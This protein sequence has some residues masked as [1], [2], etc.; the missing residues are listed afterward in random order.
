MMVM[1]LEKVPTSTRGHLSRWLIEVKAGVFVGRVSALVR[2]KLWEKVNQSRKEGA[3]VQIWSTN[4][5]QGFD[6]RMEGDRD[7]KIVDMEGLLLV[8]RVVS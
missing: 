5:E 1:I 7:R 4:N 3:V 2:E 6:M 8:K